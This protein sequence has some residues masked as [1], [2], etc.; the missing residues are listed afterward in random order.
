MFR[1]NFKHFNHIDC[2]INAFTTK[3]RNHI[4]GTMVNEGCYYVRLELWAL[5]PKRL[6]TYVNDIYIIE[7]FHD[8]N[9]T[10]F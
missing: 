5:E 8:Y 10:M 4:F 9:V 3:W 7:T 2:K 1:K 6:Y